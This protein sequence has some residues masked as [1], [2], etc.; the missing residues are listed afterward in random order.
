MIGSII[1]FL[2]VLSVLVLVH[3][4]GHFVMAKRA[5]IW[6]EEFGFGIPPKVLGKKIGET[7]YSLNLLPFGGF[8]RLHGENTEDQITNAKRAFLNKSKKTRIGII[9]AGVLMNFLLA[10]FAF[11][12]VYSF[13]GIPKETNNLRAVDISAN[14]PALLSGIVAGDLIRSVDGVKVTSVNQFIKLIEEKKG[15]K[16]TL[17][18]ERSSGQALQEKNI[19]IVPRVNPPS[20]E[21]PLGVVISTT[22]IYFPPIYLRPFVGIYYG[23]GDAIFW[24]K[25]VVGGFGKM[26]TG[27]FVGQVPKDI[28]GPV[29]IFAITSEAAK[30]GVLA[31]INFIG[32]LSVNLAIINVLPF[33][34]LDGGR[35]LFIAIEAVTGKK[36]MPKV[37]NAIHTAGMIILLAL[38]FAITAH[39]IQGLIR[40]GSI[41]GFLNSFVK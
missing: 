2:L 11:S 27:L 22:E 37:E 29:G 4:L 23:F 20:D 33:P 26:I 17:A 32:I 9:V 36:V 5:G 3:E 31:V 35:L 30:F 21:G 8:V 14:S 38:I 40:A 1:V 18:I 24:G 39:D 28:A 41:S 19:S 13:S 7:I 25:A 10:I 12:V 6:V 34:A 16:V 15:K